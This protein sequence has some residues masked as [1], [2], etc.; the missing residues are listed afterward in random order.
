[1]GLA[2][3]RYEHDGVPVFRYRIPAQPTRDEAYH[4]TAV[5]GSEAFHAWLAEVRPD[6]LH[7]HSFTTGIGL[8][9]IRVARAQG[10]RVFVT[11]HLPSLGYMCQTGELMQWGEY[12]CDGIVIPDK[13]AA[14]TLTRLGL[15]RAAARIVGAIPPPTS[16]ALGAIPGR[17]GTT[18]GM[19]ALIV[20]Q[21]GKQ[22]EL[23]DLVE[24]VFVLNESG[25]AMLI[26]NGSPAAKLS[27]NRLG[28]SQTVINRKP[29]P[30]VRPTKV[31]VRFGYLGRFYRSKGLI[32][33]AQ[34]LQSLPRDLPFEFEL[35]GPLLDVESQRLAG[36]M[37]RML[38]DDPR[39]HFEDAVAP[40]DVPAALAAL[41]VLVCPSTGFENGPT[42]AMEAMAAGTPVI[43]SRVGNL[44]ELID[45]GVNGCLVDARDVKALARTLAAAAAN[46][47][48]TIDAWR[49][50][51]PC[52][53]T[54]DDIA[55]DYLTFYEA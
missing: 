54:M 38:H 46:P 15:P 24:R 36:E 6:I 37:K 27:I 4:R 12:P 20:E 35:R 52:I 9:D 55:R 3:E 23:F 10:I 2:D 29:G 53:R 5:R 31:P 22:R 17:V 11:C 40:R 1:V 43:A 19:S 45:N 14:C 13:C 26:S 47:A 21:E 32:E 50:S 7:V 28:T 44:P 48:R 39:V 49:R 51:L 34:A 25:R 16:A 8:P 33:L 42:I 18:L 30:D 41:D